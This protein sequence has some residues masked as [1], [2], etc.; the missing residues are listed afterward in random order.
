MYVCVC[1]TVCV[2][3][4]VCVCLTVCLCAR[5]SVVRSVSITDTPT[6]PVPTGTILSQPR[7]IH[8]SVTEY[9]LRVYVLSADVHLVTQKYTPQLP[10]T[11]T[12][13]PIPTTTPDSHKVHLCPD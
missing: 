9:V 3:V 6:E 11:L 10:P 13:I 8:R 2:C 7:Q 1:L 12:L 4:C 5:A